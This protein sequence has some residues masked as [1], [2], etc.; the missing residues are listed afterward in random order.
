MEYISTDIGVDHSDHFLFKAW[1]THT[2]KLIYSTEH[3]TYAT[4]TATGISKK[5]WK[6]SIKT[7]V[8]VK[9]WSVWQSGN[10]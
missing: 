5:T 9:K 6:I 10:I 2:D 1:T 8:H 4:V 7:A 3:P